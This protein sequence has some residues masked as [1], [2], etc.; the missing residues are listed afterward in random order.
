MDTSE[1][2]IQKIV[3]RDLKKSTIQKLRRKG[4]IVFCKR[5]K[6]FNVYPI[7]NRNIILANFVLDKKERK[8][9][10]KRK[11]SIGRNPPKGGSSQFFYIFIKKEI[12]WFK[13]LLLNSS[14]I[15]NL[16][17][18][19]NILRLK[20]QLLNSMQ[21]ASATCSCFA[22]Q[23]AKDFSSLEVIKKKP[24]PKIKSS[25][26]VKQTTITNESNIPSIHENL[27]QKLFKLGMPFTK[28]NKGSKQYQQALD[29]VKKNF[30]RY[31]TEMLD[32]FNLAKEYFTNVDF[33]Y[34]PKKISIN[35]FFKYSKEELQNM[36]H[37]GKYNVKSWFKEFAK[38]RNHI[39]EN[40]MKVKTDQN[41]E[42]TQVMIEYWKNF[43]QID[44]ISAYEKR[45]FVIFTT[46][47]HNY[48]KIK[49][50]S[51]RTIFEAI[52]NSM[53]K[54]ENPFTLTNPMFFNGE[55]FW[56]MVLPKLLINNK[57]IQKRR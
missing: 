47:M 30:K 37:L 39:E 31:R 46:K 50:L 42:L 44:K 22:S 6:I 12:E 51:V 23:N 49:Q 19:T 57:I 36:P 56:T 9:N 54:S 13:Q 26:K 8:K 38:G 17:E 4:Y 35:S 55:Y 48:A 16:E 53:F 1:V 5:K 40:F 24:L 18:S 7:Q 21:V 34:H 3:M 32:I 52:N 28:H 10:Q 45:A 29:H 15:N 33:V 43:K 2:F 27:L 41:P 14:K 25:Y 20:K 11:K